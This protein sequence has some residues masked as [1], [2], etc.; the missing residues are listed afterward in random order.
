MPVPV[1]GNKTFARELDEI[2]VSLVVRMPKPYETS[3]AWGG[4]VGENCVAILVPSGFT[5]ARYS[6]LFESLKFVCNGAPTTRRSLFEAKTTRNPPEFRLVD[7]NCH[8]FR[9]LAVSVRYH[10]PRLTTLVPLLAISIQSSYELS[11]SFRVRLLD[12]MNSEMMTSA[13]AA[14]AR[15]RPQKNNANFIFINR[16][17]CAG[18]YGQGET[19]VQ[20]RLSLNQTKASWS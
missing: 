10:P 8:F 3:G 20:N 4:N 2:R 6:P 9:S 12:A 14:F 7:G 1:T 16:F 18:Q 13:E 5:R 19:T 17:A 11:S 15:R